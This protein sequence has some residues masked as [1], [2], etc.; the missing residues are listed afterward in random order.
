[1]T[2]YF[3]KNFRLRAI[4]EFPVCFQGGNKCLM[5]KSLRDHVKQKHLKSDQFNRCCPNS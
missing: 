5:V 2:D 3:L 1:M 4:E